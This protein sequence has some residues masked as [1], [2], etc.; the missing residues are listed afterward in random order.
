[1]KD[2]NILVGRHE[3]E[4]GNGLRI[5]VVTIEEIQP[6]AAPP[7]HESFRSLFLTSGALGR[8]MPLRRGSEARRLTINPKILKPLVRPSMNT[9][10][11]SHQNW[12]RLPRSR[13]YQLLQVESPNLQVA[14]SRAPAFHLCPQTITEQGMVQRD[15][16][17][18]R[19]RL[20][21]LVRKVNAPANH[22]CLL[23]SSCRPICQD[24]KPSILI[25]A[26]DRSLICFPRNHFQR[27]VR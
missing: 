23:G 20:D 25:N 15:Q 22:R 27:A 16:A 18:L 13:Y 2:R 6:R 11:D 10:E 9:C 7:A 21:S 5:K 24:E 4:L 8:M 17:L 3:D 12:A 14:Q 19:I 1:L 26:E